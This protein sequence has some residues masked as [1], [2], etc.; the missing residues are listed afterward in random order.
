VDGNLST[1]TT[2]TILVPM[3]YVRN[4]MNGWGE[5]PMMEGVK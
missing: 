5:R 1:S 2:T 4:M 3:D